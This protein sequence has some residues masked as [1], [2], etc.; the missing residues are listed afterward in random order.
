MHYLPFKILI[1]G[2]NYLK[3]F[4]VVIGAT[5]LKVFFLIFHP[6]FQFHEN[7]VGI[8][9]LTIVNPLTDMVHG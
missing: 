4:C 1:S 7:K 9:T 6:D 5:I 2:C 3:S 8:S